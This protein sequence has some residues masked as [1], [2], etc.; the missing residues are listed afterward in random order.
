ME[1]YIYILCSCLALL[2]TQ[3][4][5]VKHNWVIQ[6]NISICISCLIYITVAVKSSRWV[7]LTA[8]IHVDT[9]SDI[10]RLPRA[11]S[12]IPQNRHPL[13]RNKILRDSQMWSKLSSVLLIMG[14]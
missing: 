9:C 14:L 11:G 13:W 10:V 2:L 6:I 4:L 1:D 12:T 5:L 7:Y 3:I 8:V